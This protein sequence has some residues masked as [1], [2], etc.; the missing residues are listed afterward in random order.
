MSAST[1]QRVSMRGLRLQFSLNLLAAALF[2]PLC[3]APL[4]AQGSTTVS[5]DASKN[6]HAINPNIYGFGMFMN[7]DDV[8][9]TSQLATMNAPVHRFGGDLSSTYNW[10]QDAW[11]LSA[12]WYWESY[13]MSDPF[14]E[15]G[16]ADAFISASEA[17]NSEP[18]ITVPMLPYIAKVGAGATAGTA[19]LWSFSVKKY[20]AQT[21]GC[22]R[23]ADSADPWVPDAGSGCATATT[24][25]KNDPTDAY[26]TNSAAIQTA[27]IDHLIAKWGNSTTATGVKYYMLDN[28]PSDWIGTHAD[29]HPNPETYDELW[30]DIQAYAGAIKAADPNAKIIGPEEWGWW[31]MW[32]SSKDQAGGTGAGSDYAT[33]GNMYY[34]PWLLKQLAAYKQANGVSLIDILSVHCYSDTNPNYNQDTRMLWDP[35][36]TD[37]GG[38][39]ADGGQNGGIVDYIPTMQAWVKAAFPNGDGPQIGCTEYSGWGED[40]TTLAGATVHADVLGIFGYYGFDMGAYWGIPTDSSGQ[41]ETLVLLAHKMYRNYDGKLSTFGDTSVQTTVANPDNLSAFAAVR[42]S[43]GAMT[44]MVINKQTS[45]TAVT[46]NLANFSNGGTAKAYQISSASQTS[47]N[48]L[49][50]VT[51][52]ANAINATV[53]AQSVTLYVI[54]AVTVAPTAPTGLTAAGGNGLVT[55]NWTASTNATSYNVYRGT[56]AGGESTTPIATGVTAVT[57]VDSTVTNGTEYYYEVAAV[58]SI[59]TSG[60]SNEASAT[61]SNTDPLFTATATAAPNPVTQGN[62]TTLTVAVKCTENTMT[63]GSVSIVVLDPGGNVVQTTPEASQSFTNGQTQTYTPAVPIAASATVGT[64]TVEVNVSGSSGQLWTAIPSA[65]TFTVAAAPPPAAPAFTITG[66]VTPATITATGSTSISATFQNTGG[67]LTNGNIEVQI[68][69]T[70]GSGASIGGDAPNYNACNVAAGTSQTL[71]FTFTP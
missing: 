17:A 28:E 1:S 16:F 58:N 56:T 6:Q 38:W 15:G 52:T 51:V 3:V 14:T 60:M 39:F 48:S 13:L 63:G 53:P 34:Y 64:Y 54:P 5:V 18:I 20:G 67:D 8:V 49:G 7:S 61:P 35:T 26:T 43:D 9:Q 46:V 11:N 21:T 59:G 36:Y 27:W 29:V 2:A 25:V 42:T 32:L 50:S 24:Y 10:Q 69:P 40:D 31:P 22:G 55:L 45:S 12:D 41:T 33:H 47:I 65:G 23:L 57:Y 37:A 70:S 19:S 44:V 4:G 62:S 30:A 66:S 68:Y 71:T